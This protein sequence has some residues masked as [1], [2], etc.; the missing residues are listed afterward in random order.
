M[1]VEGGSRRRHE[2][3]DGRSPHAEHE[4]AL[5]R[6]A[7]DL[8]RLPAN[9]RRLRRE[10]MPNP[11]GSFIWYELMTTDTEAGGRFYADVVGWSVGEFG[12]GVPG[13]RIFSAGETGVA[14]M[15]ALPAGA[16]DSGMRSG[17]FGYVGVD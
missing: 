17:W 3:D 15:M 10:T 7:H 5:R 14:G 1:A 13:Y 4:D 16:S 11:H 2:E 12:A 8:R 9:P 6:A